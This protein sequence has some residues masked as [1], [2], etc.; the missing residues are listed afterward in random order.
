MRASRFNRNER[1]REWG[2]RMQKSISRLFGQQQKIRRQGKRWKMRTLL[3][4]SNRLWRWWRL[5]L[6]R[7]D[8]NIFESSKNRILFGNNFFFAVA[9]VVVVD[10]WLS[11]LGCSCLYRQWQWQVN[12]L[13]I[14]K[15]IFHCSLFSGLWPLLATDPTAHAHSLTR[16]LLVRSAVL[17]CVTAV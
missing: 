9:V 8:P 17:C 6:Q 4:V 10:C 12:K 11:S 5:E 1:K 15:V 2:D 16:N 7:G 13:Q 3:I 14:V